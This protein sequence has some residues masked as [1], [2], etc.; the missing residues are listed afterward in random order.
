MSGKNGTHATECVIL[1]K[2][3]GQY[4]SNFVMASD[5]M[6]SDDDDDGLVYENMISLS[7]FLH[8][9]VIGHFVDTISANR[10]DFAFHSS[11][12]T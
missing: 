12:S 1:P 10:S 3:F 7:S 11:S 6:M 4:L 9:K 8:E 2:A 5:G